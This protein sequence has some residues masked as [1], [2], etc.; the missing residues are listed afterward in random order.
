MQRDVDNSFCN[1]HLL[2]RR[3]ASEDLIGNR[4]NPIKIA[5]KNTSVNWSKYSKPWDVVYDYPSHGYGQIMV[6]YLPSELP[7]EIP[8]GSNPKLHSFFPEHK[9]LEDNYSHSEIVTF[10]ENTKIQGNVELPSIVKKEFRTIISD[11]TLI[12]SYPKS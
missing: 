3:F 6:N 1:W 4:L 8:P 12:L 5:Y 11:K 7:K 9:P 10:K 2:Y